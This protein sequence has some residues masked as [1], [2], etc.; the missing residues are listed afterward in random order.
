M[1]GKTVLEDLLSECRKRIDN[2]EKKLISTG[3]DYNIFNI[4]GHTSKELTHSKIIASLLDPRG[5]HHMGT[6]FMDAFIDVVGIDKI[7]FDSSHSSVITEKPIGKV[8]NDYEYLDGGRIDIILSDWDGHNIIIENKI[9]A[10]DQ[11]RQLVRYSRHKTD[12]IPILYLTP[13]GKKPTEFSCK[14]LKEGDDYKCISYQEHILQWLERCAQIDDVPENI[15]FILNQYSNVV[16]KITNRSNRNKMK[17]DIVNLIV[18]NKENG[19]YLDMSF[20]IDSLI[21]RIQVKAQ[22]DFW[23]EIGEKLK[24]KGI[25]S[26]F[27]LDFKG[28]SPMQDIEDPIGETVFKYLKKEKD[29][30]YFGYDVRVGSYNEQDVFL[31]LCVNERIFF[32]IHLREECSQKS[33]LVESLELELEKQSKVKEWTLIKNDHLRLAWRYPNISYIEK[34]KMINFGEVLKP[35]EYFKQIDA[36][37]K[38]FIAVKN[39]LSIWCSKQ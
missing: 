38:D 9:Y 21:E 25:E 18:N 16:K 5:R 4:L 31:K 6:K 34:L 23:K 8:E 35:S 33:E 12:S 2:C 39:K 24:G 11:Y 1:E 14:G 37:V 29:S 36:I 10:K 19:G 26:A 15:I 28:T 22:S 27:T 20:E 32:D 3:D 17:E 7:R 13:I 30:R